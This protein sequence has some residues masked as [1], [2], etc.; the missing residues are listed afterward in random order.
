[1][2]IILIIL[3]VLIVIGIIGLIS[4]IVGFIFRIVY[5][6]FISVFRI[7]V[8]LINPAIV[9]CVAYLLYSLLGIEVAVIG[10]IIIFLLW[11]YYKQ[12]YSLKADVMRAFHQ[13][14]MGTL[15]E[16]ERLLKRSPSNRA[17]VGV[18]NYYINK[19][20]LEV[21]DFDDREWLYRWTEN[22]HYPSG[23]IRKTVHVD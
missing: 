3:G 7:L 23:V 18:F 16:I 2:E 4:A 21:I 12:A 20:C 1:M 17:L 14:E 8:Y 5:S 13:V 11:I 9:T 6:V 22:R 10:L 15:H 19:G